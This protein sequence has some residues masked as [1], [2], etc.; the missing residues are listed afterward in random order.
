MET[1]LF[2]IFSLFYF[3]KTRWRKRMKAVPN[4]LT[5]TGL[6]SS[7]YFSLFLNELSSSS[8]SSCGAFQNLKLASSSTSSS[9]FKLSPQLRTVEE[10]N[11]FLLLFNPKKLGHFSRHKSRLGAHSRKKSREGK[12]KVGA[13]WKVGGK[14]KCCND[15]GAIFPALSP[16]QKRFFCRSTSLYRQVPHT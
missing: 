9:S 8:F 3:P 11:F 2:R 13:I 5:Q 14:R 12:K 4:G 10:E 7:P 16:S 1:C 15:C 6:S